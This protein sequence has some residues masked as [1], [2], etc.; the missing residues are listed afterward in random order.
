MTVWTDDDGKLVLTDIHNL[1]N[2]LDFLK[3]LL[4]DGSDKLT[5]IADKETQPKPISVQAHDQDGNPLF[6]DDAK[7]EPMMIRKNLTL[8]KIPATDLKGDP[9]T[10]E[11]K[12]AVYTDVLDQI[13]LIKTEIAKIQTVIPKP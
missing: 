10:P 5:V 8:E 2:Y 4:I 3:R 7:T 9:Y 13:S 12:N 1:L 11:F 6:H